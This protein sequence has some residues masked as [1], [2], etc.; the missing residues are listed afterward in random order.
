MPTIRPLMLLGNR[1]SSIQSFLSFDRWEGFH[2]F[3]QEEVR[4]H[5]AMFCVAKYYNILT[6]HSANIHI[7]RLLDPLYQI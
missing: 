3:E 2:H 1:L 6:S 7:S 5:Q 4:I